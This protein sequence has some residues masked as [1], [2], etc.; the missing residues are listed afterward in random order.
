MRESWS[1]LFLICAIQF[2]SF[3]DDSPLFSVALLSQPS[4]DIRRKKDGHETSPSEQNSQTITDLDFLR[5]IASRFHALAVDPIEFACLKAIIMFKSHISNLQ[6]TKFLGFI[7]FIKLIVL[8]IPGY[9]SCGEAS[10]S[11]TS[12]FKRTHS[13]YASASFRPS[14]VSSAAAAKHSY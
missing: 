10:R 3:V 8:P 7:G 14:S 6:V 5:S 9:E 2:F 13:R 4:E 1:E 12:H 11:C